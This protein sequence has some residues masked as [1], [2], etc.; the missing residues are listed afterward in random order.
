MSINVENGEHI[1]CIEQTIL[2]EIHGDGSKYCYEMFMYIYNDFIKN[3]DQDIY[4]V[5]NGD[6]K[7]NIIIHNVKNDIFTQNK[8][9]VNYINDILGKIYNTNDNSLFIVLPF[10]IFNEKSNCG[11]ALTI[12]YE[13]NKSRQIR[14]IILNSGD[15][16]EYHMIYDNKYLNYIFPIDIDYLF[17]TKNGVNDRQILIYLLH[18]FFLNVKEINSVYY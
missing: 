14:A 15:G 1:N 11:H 7:V 9:N 4:N 3:N 13:F 18:I 10:A 6:N 17:E 16:A 5:F 12:I 2:P 8:E